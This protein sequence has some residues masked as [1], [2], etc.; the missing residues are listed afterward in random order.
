MAATNCLTTE[1]GGK[2]RLDEVDP[3]FMFKPP[4][5]SEGITS[6]TWKQ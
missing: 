4:S 5:S 3:G 1:L 2:A 6:R